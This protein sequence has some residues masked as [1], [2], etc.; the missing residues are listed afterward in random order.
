MR[1]R[2]GYKIR[3]RKRFHR[4]S[5]TSANNPAGRQTEWPVLANLLIE[6][7]FPKISYPSIK[8]IALTLYACAMAR[9]SIALAWDN[10]SAYIR[11]QKLCS[12]RSGLLPGPTIGVG[13]SSRIETIAENIS[14]FELILQK[15]LTINKLKD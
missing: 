8:F 7:L 12:I 2:T 5:V 3:R 6:E 14:C 1:T 15:P 9:L 11:P 13:R 10:S 4:L